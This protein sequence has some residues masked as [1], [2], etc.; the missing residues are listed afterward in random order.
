[1]RTSMKHAARITT[2][3]VA[4]LAATALSSPAAYAAGGTAPA[5]VNRYVTNTPNGFDVLLTNKCGRVMSVQV[6]V[7][8]AGDSPC[9]VM[10]PNVSKLY[11][12]ES[13]F[14]TYDRTAVC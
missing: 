14:G 8:N 9:Y 13:I 3:A 6:V 12:H 2:T 10:S 7:N 4:L 11:I 5:C 1:M